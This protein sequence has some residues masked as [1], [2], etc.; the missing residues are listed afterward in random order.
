[1]KSSPL[2]VDRKPGKGGKSGGRKK[3]GK[4][5]K[6]TRAT[7]YR[8]E[9]Q[10]M[11]DVVHDGR[12]EKKEFF[13]LM[14]LLGLPEVDRAAE[15]SGARAYTHLCT[16]ALTHTCLSLSVCLYLS[17]SVGLSVCLSVP[18]LSLTHTHT[19]ARTHAHAHTHK[20]TRTH[21][22]THAHTHTCV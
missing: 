5:N 2:P 8:A 7:Y 4:M 16:H 9:F 17:V 15:V 11:G 13:R 10:S 12:L 1:M 20:H 22:R 3:G 19:H 14:T 18:P 6:A 21:A